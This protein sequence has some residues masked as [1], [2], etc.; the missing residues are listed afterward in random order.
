MVVWARREGRVVEGVDNIS[1]SGTAK[2]RGVVRRAVMFFD[3]IEG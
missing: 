2:V 1:G 3:L